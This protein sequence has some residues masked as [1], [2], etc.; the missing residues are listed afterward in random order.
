[1]GWAGADKSRLCGVGQ[2]SRVDNVVTRPSLV[3]VGRVGGEGQWRIAGLSVAAFQVAV[4]SV[5]VS[6]VRVRPRLSNR[7]RLR[8]AMRV[9][10]HQSLGFTPR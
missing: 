7:R 9:C 5:Q 2:T 10:S 3:L 6:P 4:V 1:V 8:A